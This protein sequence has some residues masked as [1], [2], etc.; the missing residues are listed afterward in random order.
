MLKEIH[1]FSGLT[2]AAFVGVH[3]FNHLLVLHS[4]ALHLRFMKAA[5]KVYRHPVVEGVLLTAVVVQILSGIYLVT[6]KWPRAEGWFDW[7]HIASGLYLSLFLANHVR[8]VIVG[9]RKLHF[10]TNLYYGAG[11]MNM[12]PQKLIFIPYYALAVL[13]FFSHVASIHRVKMEEFVSP[14]AAAQQAV[15]ILILGCLVTFLIIFRMSHLKLPA[16]MMKKIE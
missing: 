10:D 16:E 2:I 1:Y 4:E 7:L 15:G 3:L 13:S 6:Q 5:R 9:R 12:W 11:V 8:A 14:A